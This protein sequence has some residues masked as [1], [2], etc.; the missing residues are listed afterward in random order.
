MQGSEER[1]FRP[2]H[3]YDPSV[4]GFDSYFLLGDTADL[5]LDTVKGTLK[6]IEAVLVEMSS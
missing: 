6:D 2:G 3:F 4:R 5:L 1:D